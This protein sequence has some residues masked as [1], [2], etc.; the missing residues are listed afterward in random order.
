MLFNNFWLTEDIYWFGKYFTGY[1]LP[2][3]LLAPF[4]DI[5]MF[6][7]SCLF[8]RREEE[9]C[10]ETLIL[11]KGERAMSHGFRRTVICGMLLASVSNMTTSAYAEKKEEP[12]K[13]VEISLHQDLTP[14]FKT[15]FY[16]WIKPST[17]A[18]IHVKNTVPD[19][20]VGYSL[21]EGGGLY[22]TKE[23]KRAENFNAMFFVENYD[24]TDSP[25]YPNDV[26]VWF[27]GIRHTDIH[28]KLPRGATAKV[29][30]SSLKWSEK[31]WK[32]CLEDEGKA[33]CVSTN[34]KKG[35][36]KMEKK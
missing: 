12:K 10:G 14:K 22:I 18:S 27:G 4:F 9:C 7:H 28:I 8:S 31:D 26:I 36:G 30:V 16:M 33:H 5:T 6:P 32:R 34:V 20:E 23:R 11:K 35:T 24:D 1:E 19:F 25:R 17:D 3:R 15:A 21:G 2:I 29:S 13:V